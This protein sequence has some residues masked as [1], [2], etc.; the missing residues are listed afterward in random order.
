MCQYKAAYDL[1]NSNGDAS[2]AQYIRQFKKWKFEKNLRSDQ[3]K[4][5]TKVVRNRKSNGKDS[6]VLIKDGPVS[7]SRLRKEMSR[8]RPHEHDD[9]SGT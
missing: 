3:W 5:I 6:E 8:Y 4:R 1:D 9:C 7:D 2:K